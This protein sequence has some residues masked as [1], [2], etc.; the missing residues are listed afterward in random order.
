MT[1]WHFY[2]NLVTTVWA[3]RG[4]RIIFEATTLN[5]QIP[6]A[7]KDDTSQA[8]ALALSGSEHRAHRRDDNDNNNNNSKCQLPLCRRFFHFVPVNRCPC[9]LQPP[10]TVL[11]CIRRSI[12]LFFS[13]LLFGFASEGQK[14]HVRNPVMWLSSHFISDCQSSFFSYFFP[15]SL[16][17]PLAL[18]SFTAGEWFARLVPGWRSGSRCHWDTSCL[19]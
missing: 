7:L 17:F 10:D 9:G 6:R 15:P 14:L 19:P 5:T 11:C 18:I 3:L 12:F 1:F 2:G 16:R 4:G 13:F 8:A